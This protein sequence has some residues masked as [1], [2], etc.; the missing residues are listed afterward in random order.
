MFAIPDAQ[1][2]S[3][4]NQTSGS[5]MDASGYR[6]LDVWNKA[7]DFVETVYTITHEFPAD[8]KYGLTSQIRRAAVSIPSNIAEGYGR[9]SEGDYERF[10]AISQGS[11]AEVET[12]FILSVRLQFV[13]RE[14]ATPIWEQLQEIGRMLAGLRKSVKVR[15]G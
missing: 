5:G 8:E 7:M 6:Q 10:L 11:L 1:R 12:Q 14:A 13:T 9:K 15:R 2:T 3:P 4:N